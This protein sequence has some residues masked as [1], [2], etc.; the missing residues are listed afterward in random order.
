MYFIYFTLNMHV[1]CLLLLC[2]VSD[3]K[4]KLKNIFE[5]W[6]TSQ[7][8]SLTSRAELAFWL[9]CITS[10]NEPNHTLGVCKR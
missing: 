10:H 1:M 4:K 6:L 9:V 7:T 8:S 2:D 3:S 5:F